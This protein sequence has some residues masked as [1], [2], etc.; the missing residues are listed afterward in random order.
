MHGPIIVCVW[1]RESENRAD[2]QWAS[3]IIKELTY[4]QSLFYAEVKIDEVCMSLK[5]TFLLLW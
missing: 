2:K 3:I 4:E 5:S 1:E